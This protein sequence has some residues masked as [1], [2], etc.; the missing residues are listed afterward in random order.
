METLEEC[1]QKISQDPLKWSYY[2]NPSLSTEEIWLDNDRAINFIKDYFNY[3]GKSKVFDDVNIE[4]N[5]G[6]IKNR[7][8]HIVSTFLLGIEIVS[9]F[10]L[11]TRRRDK[12]NMN[13]QYYWF[14]TCLYHDIG[15]AYEEENK[16][17]CERLK[18]VSQDGIEA[19][20]EICELQYINNREFKTYSKHTVDFYLRCRAGFYQDERNP[21][22]DH[23]IVGGLLLY[24]KLRKQFA[25]AWE[26]RIE[27]AHSRASF[28]VHHEGTGRKLHL[29]NEHYKAYAKAADAIITHNIWIST[30]QEYITKCGAPQKPF[31]TSYK[32]IAYTNKLCFILSL[33]DTLEPLKRGAAY[34]KKIYICPAK[35]YSGFE[36]RTDTDTFKALYKDIASLEE[37][38]SVK[39]NIKYLVNNKVSIKIAKK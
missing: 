17:K 34:L 27:K 22:M 11:E 21:V 1:Y 4:L 10:G 33:A 30:L 24:D 29:S 2:D 6:K 13:F 31:S 3:A 8:C 7:A 5:Y 14:L 12:N 9:C 19:L 23:G 39:V 16:N 36:I 32:K 38:V 37:W 26:N 35:D 28:Y 20:Q 18:M 25:R 15:Y